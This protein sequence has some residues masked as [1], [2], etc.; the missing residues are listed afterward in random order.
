MGLPSCKPTEKKQQI[1]FQMEMKVDT[2]FCSAQVQMEQSHTGQPG[3]VGRAGMSLILPWASSF[4]P[5]LPNIHSDLQSELHDASTPVQLA[6]KAPQRF[7]AFFRS[8]STFFTGQR[9]AISYLRGFPPPQRFLRRGFS[10]VESSQETVQAEETLKMPQDNFHFT[11][12][13]I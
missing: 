8:S 7:K 9:D 12:G 5:G 1:S 3:G 6:C 2:A 4:C 11:R 13:G 10:A